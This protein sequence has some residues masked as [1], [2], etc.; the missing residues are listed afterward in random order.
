MR[1]TERKQVGG[2]TITTYCHYTRVDENFNIRRLSRPVWS[3]TIFT[4]T[5]LYSGQGFTRT[6][7]FKLAKAEFR[8]LDQDIG[9]MQYYL[10]WKR[11]KEIE[12]EAIGVRQGA[13]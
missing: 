12:R 10:A 7:A 8:W 13:K 5:H 3:V 6:Q 4:G 11:L 9:D 1:F 2:L